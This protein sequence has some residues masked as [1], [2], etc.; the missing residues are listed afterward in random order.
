MDEVSGGI[1]VPVS[2]RSITKPLVRALHTSSSTGTLPGYSP[3]APVNFTH[4]RGEEIG[5]R[6]SWLRIAKR[7][8]MGQKSTTVKR[9]VKQRRE[10]NRISLRWSRHLPW[11]TGESVVACPW[12]SANRF[13]QGVTAEQIKICTHLCPYEMKDISSNCMICGILWSFLPSFLSFLE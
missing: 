8:R 7:A 12:V 3:Y 10:E 11:F 5:Y 1:T 13:F 4:I 9:R 6:D 2:R